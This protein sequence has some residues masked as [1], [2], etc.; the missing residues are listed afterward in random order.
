MALRRYGLSQRRKAV[1]FTQESFAE[2][3]GVERT[4]VVRWEAGETEPLPW[5]RPKMAR[6]LEVSIDQLAQLLT[7]AGQDK[8]GSE[9]HCRG[10][11][12]E[13]VDAPADPSPGEMLGGPSHAMLLSAAS[14]NAITYLQERWHLLVRADNLFGPR[15]VLRLVHE[16]IELIE[17]LLRDAR[18][19]VR[20]SLLSLGAEYAE[21]AAWLHEDADDQTATFWTS[22]ALEWA[23]AAG[24]HQLVAWALFRRS[25]QVANGRDAAQTIGLARAAQGTGSPLPDQMRAAITQQEAYGL[26]LDRDEAACQ[27]KLDE[28]LRWAAPVDLH[29]DARSGHGAFCTESYIELQRAK[30]WQTLGRPW[31]AVPAYKAALAGLPVTYNRD[32]GHGL[33]QLAGALVAINEPEHAA[34]VASEALTIASG[35][36]S[37]RTL[38]HIQ[39]VGRQLRPHAKLLGV[40]QLFG[41][42]AVAAQ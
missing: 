37:G 24:N 9:A 29:G 12:D 7:E 27:C 42:L 8:A 40:A 13:P 35:C 30:C 2:R 11:I 22:R 32:R 36:G 26:A 20:T 38:L 34:S 16:Q 5:V 18:G 19:G 17:P 39:A 1:G 25:Q 21:S 10:G 41:D 3:L 4:T 28:A 33:A 6:A 14:E 15:R 31:R 23:H